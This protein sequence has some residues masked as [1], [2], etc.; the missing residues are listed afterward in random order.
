[1]NIKDSPLNASHEEFVKLKTRFDELRKE[2]DDLHQEWENIANVPNS[3][4]EKGKLIL[5]EGK[6]LEE[7]NDVVNRTL[8]LMERQLAKIP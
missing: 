4:G 6:L 3:E 8:A 5:R 2:L 7:L 1:M